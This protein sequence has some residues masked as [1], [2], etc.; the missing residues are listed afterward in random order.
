MATQII[1]IY[2]KGRS[3]DLKCHSGLNG[4]KDCHLACVFN[5]FCGSGGALSNE[6]SYPE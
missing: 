4:C 6:E 5:V 2:K 3:S 1:Y